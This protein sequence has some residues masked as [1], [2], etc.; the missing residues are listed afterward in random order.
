MPACQEKQHRQ[1]KQKGEPSRGRQ[2]RLLLQPPYTAYEREYGCA[3]LLLS[4]SQSDNRRPSCSRSTRC[5]R[6][7]S[8]MSWVTTTRLVLRLRL[9]SSSWSNTPCAV[10][11]SRL[12]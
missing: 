2:C 9:S 5:M 4:V 10:C 1:C 12:P 6:P 7:A 3:H 8:S 11:R